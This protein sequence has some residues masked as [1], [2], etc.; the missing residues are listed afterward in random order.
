MK[1]IEMANNVRLRQMNLEIERLEKEVS[2]LRAKLG[3]LDYDGVLR[4][5]RTSCCC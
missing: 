5:N 1:Q 2:R 4:Y 3:G